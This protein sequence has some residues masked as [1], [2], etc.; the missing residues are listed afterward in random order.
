MSDRA[1]TVGVV[2]LGMMGSGIAQSLLDVGIA[3]GP[4]AAA[5]GSLLTTVGGSSDAYDRA[6]EA[7]RALSVRTIYAGESGAGM[8]LKL[9]KNALSF[10]KIS[11]PRFFL[12]NVRVLVI[13]FSISREI[14]LTPIFYFPKS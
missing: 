3:G 6:A 4:E 5:S 9:L 2:G 11:R 8:S 12:P 1:E 7:L 14:E 10:A 13:K